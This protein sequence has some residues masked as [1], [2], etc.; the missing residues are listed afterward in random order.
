MLRLRQRRQILSRPREKGAHLHWW[1]EW[2]YCLQ[3]GVGCPKLCRENLGCIS[4]TLKGRREDSKD[5]VFRPLLKYLNLSLFFI[6]GG[7]GK[8]PFGT[9]VTFD[10][11]DLD[12]ENNNP[13]YWGDFTTKIR[14]LFA[15]D[16]SRKYLISAAPQPE[17]IE[18][19][20]QNLVD[21]LKNVWVDICF[22]QVIRLLTKIRCPVYFILFFF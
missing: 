18:S 10:G 20:D 1:C 8:R 13:K 2:K 16:T 9:G 7:S 14:S 4:G 21:F 19:P 6:K 11:I 3:F 5:T 15:T 12:P 17:P 22:I